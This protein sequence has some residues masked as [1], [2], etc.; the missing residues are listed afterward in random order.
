ME[1][2]GIKMLLPSSAITPKEARAKGYYPLT[3]RFNLP[4]ERELLDRTQRDLKGKDYVLVGP[5]HAPEIWRKEKEM[6]FAETSCV[7][8]PHE[9]RGSSR[10]LTV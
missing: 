10:P 7:P 9:P 4:A 1:R 3:T 2:K 8:L 5:P 6:I